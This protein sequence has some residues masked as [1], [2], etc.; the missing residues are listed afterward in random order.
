MWHGINSRWKTQISI[1]MDFPRGTETVLL[2]C[3]FFLQIKRKYPGS[4]VSHSSLVSYG[5]D[6]L[7]FWSEIFLQTAKEQ[8]GTHHPVLSLG[9]LMQIFL[10]G[11]SLF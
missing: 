7:V 2:D 10:S 5:K 6:V 1:I 8:S 4:W 3:C 11:H 9:S